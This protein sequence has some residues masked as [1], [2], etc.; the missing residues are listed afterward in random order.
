MWRALFAHMQSHVSRSQTN[1]DSPTLSK[2]RS[3][4]I[5]CICCDRSQRTARAAH[6]VLMCCVCFHCI[7]AGCQRI[8][9]CQRSQLLAR[10]LSVALLCSVSHCV[11]AIASALP[12]VAASDRDCL[13][14]ALYSPA[15]DRLGLSEQWSQHAFYASSGVSVWQGVKHFNRYRWLRSYG[16]ATDVAWREFFAFKLRIPDTDSW[17]RIAQPLAVKERRVAVAHT[18]RGYTRLSGENARNTSGQQAGSGRR[19]RPPGNACRTRSLFPSVPLSLSDC[20]DGVRCLLRCCGAVRQA[21]PHVVEVG[22]QV[23][24]TT[25]WLGIGRGYRWRETRT[26]RAAQR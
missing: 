4:L 26:A 22:A 10:N 21:A 18:A 13:L 24:G 5:C 14:L 23:N 9:R 12:F 25:P 20:L 16:R 1:A 11:C 6:T 8:L 2:F 3:I 7:I 19:S 17:H 15:L